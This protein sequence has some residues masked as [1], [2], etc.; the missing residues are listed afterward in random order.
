VLGLVIPESEEDVSADRNIL[1]II[2]QAGILHYWVDP[3]SET[4]LNFLEKNPC[5]DIEDEQQI[6]PFA[7]LLAER[8]PAAQARL[9]RTVE[10]SV[11]PL[12]LMSGVRPMTR[13]KGRS[14]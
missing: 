11:G 13:F 1:P 9:R 12:V 7:M 14:C 2:F 3:L 5:P 4:V 8:V 6:A 10:S